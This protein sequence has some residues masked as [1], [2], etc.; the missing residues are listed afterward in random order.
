MKILA[1]TVL[2]TLIAP[3]EV[4]RHLAAAP[5]QAAPLFVE[6]AGVGHWVGVSWRGGSEADFG[7]ASVAF[8]YNGTE[9]EPAVDF[10]KEVAEGREGALSGRLLEL[11]RRDASGRLVR[12]VDFARL[13]KLGFTEE[14]AG[15]LLPLPQ[16][17][18]SLYF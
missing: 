16:T 12:Q 14:E 7:A 10:V 8:Y 9:D 6:L 13:K 1:M 18:G 5:T 15:K 11:R 4:D 17:A 3:A 2:L